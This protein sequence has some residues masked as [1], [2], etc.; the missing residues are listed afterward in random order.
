MGINK[1]RIYI[2]SRLQPSVVVKASSEEKIISDHINL[3]KFIK[4]AFF[5]YKGKSSDYLLTDKEG[6][7]ISSVALIRHIRILLRFSFESKR[8]I[9]GKVHFQRWKRESFIIYDLFSKIRNVSFI[10]RT[11]LEVHCHIKSRIPVSPV[12]NMLKQI[13]QHTP[14]KQ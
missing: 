14:G 12:N 8:T 5:T 10:G 9:Q 13:E 2:Q 6:E 3:G 4:P 7:Y 1:L 11:R